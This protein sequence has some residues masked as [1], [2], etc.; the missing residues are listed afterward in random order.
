MW[1][2]RDPQK[3][4]FEKGHVHEKLLHSS[5]DRCNLLGRIRLPHAHVH[6]I[7]AREQEFVVHRP[8]DGDHALHSLRVI[9]L[10]ESGSR[11]ISTH[12]FCHFHFI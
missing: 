6:L 5:T 4:I 2:L 11:I 9:H 12:A 1:N 10:P 3:V 7:A 8:H